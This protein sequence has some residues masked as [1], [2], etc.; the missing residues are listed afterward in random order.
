MIRQFC[1]HCLKSVELPA[2][3]SGTEAPCP[4]CGMSFSIPN[5]YVPQVDPAAVKPTSAPPPAPIPSAPASTVP[6]PN[7]TPTPPAA[8]PNRPPPPP[9]YAPLPGS[10]SSVTPHYSGSISLGL[11]SHILAW[12]PVVG[13]TL[14]L[15]STFFPWSGAYPGGYTAYTQSFWGALGNSLSSDTSAETVMK[16]ERNLELALRNDWWILLPY[17][18]TIVLGAVLAWADRLVTASDFAFRIG[19][20]GTLRA[21]VWPRRG[22]I[23]FGITAVS[24]LL[25]AFES[26]RGFG[27]ESAV[28]TIS[29]AE[30]KDDMDKADNSADRQK[31]LVKMGV[32]KASFGMQ[33]GTAYCLAAIMHLVILTAAG[34]RVWMETRGESAPP[35]RLALEW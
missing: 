23:L 32:K 12:L 17:L 14:I 33:N 4:S 22:L 15:L 35:P 13:F 8:D 26:F 19:P 31:I 21:M 7:P 25:F 16:Q 18:L 3:A 34:G 1:P 9:G 24:I 30:Y 10:P 2:T 27:L 5:A 29:T 6:P 20:L 28:R 11:S